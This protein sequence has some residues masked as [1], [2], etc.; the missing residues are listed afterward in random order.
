MST[1]P[2]LYQNVMTYIQWDA[3]TGI[4]DGLFGRRQKSGLGQVDAAMY[5]FDNHRNAAT[6]QRLRDAFNAWRSTVGPNWERDPA[7]RS[8][9]ISALARQLAQSDDVDNAGASPIPISD[10]IHAR[11]GVIYLFSQLHV[12]STVAEVAVG[13]AFSAADI[14]LSF[15]NDL[16]LLGRVSEEARQRAGPAGAAFNDSVSQTMQRVALARN[17]V[18]KAGV[19]ATPVSGLVEKT[20]LTRPRPGRPSIPAPAPVATPPESWQEAA[21]RHYQ[22]GKYLVSHAVPL[23]AE[24]ISQGIDH[25]SLTAHEIVAKIR[26]ALNAAKDAVCQYITNQ[27]LPNLRLY[28][29]TIL[30]NILPTVL[31]KLTSLASALVD[32]LL[33]KFC[34]EAVPFL[35]GSRDVLKGLVNAIDASVDRFKM[36]S[37]RSVR[38]AAGHPST[39]FNTIKSTMEISLAEGLLTAMGGAARVAVEALAPGFGIIATA[40]TK[41]VELVVR[42]VIRIFELLQFRA[43]IDEAKI[44]WNNREAPDALHKRPRAFNAWYGAYASTSPIVAILTLNTGITG[45][46]MQFMD[47][48]TSDGKV[49]NED[50]FQKGVAFIDA[51]KGWGTQYLNGCGIAVSST[52]ADVKAYLAQAKSCSTNRTLGE[53]VWAAGVAFLNGS[54]FPVDPE[55]EHVNAPH[56][57]L[58]PLPPPVASG[59]P[60]VPRR[61]ATFPGAGA[62]RAPARPLRGPGE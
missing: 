2:G 46:K 16:E 61:P 41:L 35:G 28:K 44:L 1:V 48:M 59:A 13:A 45:S 40:V 54:D 24:A 25:V 51:M 39:I 43:L 50:G 37:N 14:G 15:A 11:L 55:F 19:V 34:A 47:M 52:T 42:G 57:P 6:F 26:A 32:G 60:P 31:P 38:I 17:I 29:H 27:L 4:S 12:D 22:R 18:G 53:K 7:N 8:M 23:T 49:I 9:C 5:A 20:V 30:P 10:R 62:R 58:A 36:W 3:G 33:V 56:R 21:T